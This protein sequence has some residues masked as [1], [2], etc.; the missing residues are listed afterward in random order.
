MKDLGLLAPRRRRSRRLSAWVGW[1]V[2]AALLVIVWQAGAW[3]LGVRGLDWS[4]R[5][6]IALQQHARTPA[7]L[8][9]ALA[10]W[11]RETGRYWRNQPARLVARIFARHA[12]TEPEVRRLLVFM[13]GADYG[14]RVEDWRRWLADQHRLSTGRQP[15]LPRRQRVVL[16]PLW[17]APVGLTLSFSTI[18]PIDGEIY[19][20][21]CGRAYD[22]AG[23]DADGIVRVQA[24]TGQASYLFVPD[25][26]GP[27]D[28]L[29]LALADGRLIAACRNGMI[30]AVGLDGRLQWKAAAGAKLASS[31]L[32][33]ESGER[34]PLLVAVVTETGKAVAINSANGRTVWVADVVSPGLRSLSGA[35]QA[36]ASE[37]RLSASLALGDLVGDGKPELIVLSAGGELRALSP[38]RGRVLLKRAGQSGGLGGVVFGGGGGSQ[39]QAYTADLEGGVWAV[40]RASQG[41]Q[42]APIAQLGARG[43][44]GFVAP[45]RVTAREELAD[46]VACLAGR[47]GELPGALALLRGPE[48]QWRYPLPGCA[49]GA[50]AVADL[51]GDG[52]VELAATSFGRDAR[53]ELAGWLDITSLEGHCLLRARLPAPAEAGPVVADVD[54][55]GRVEVLV[56]DRAGM[57]HCYRA[58]ALGPIEWGVL[59]GD[60]R[61]TRHAANAYAFSQTPFG[62]QKRWTPR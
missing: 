30:Y 24:R 47:A 21:S 55:D 4:I 3:Y 36:A 7:E 25:Q 23:D 53:G 2:L 59:G 26:A 62:R 13:T 44:S 12:L 31:P 19:V 49:W 6:G 60:P 56:A 43:P 58:A 20:A 41:V 48:L 35:A 42:V 61:N 16:E 22:D 8:N 57:L 9:A 18:L 38:D 1:L 51:N 52:R 10:L 39:P 54:G 37:P 34:G 40:Y 33:F 46:V 50:P 45:L 11:E 15:E 32:V 14:E 29:G 28:V 5:H 17:S 27:R